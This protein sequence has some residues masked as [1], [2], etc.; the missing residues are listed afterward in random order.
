MSAEPRIA[1]RPFHHDPTRNPADMD[2]IYVRDVEMFRAEQMDD[3]HWWMCCYLGDDT[4]RISFSVRWD[5]K[6]KRIVVH[7]VEEPDNVTYEEQLVT[8]RTPQQAVHPTTPSP[9]ADT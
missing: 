9:A 5:K 7:V 3:A 6:A 4:D 1:L 8:F 2:D